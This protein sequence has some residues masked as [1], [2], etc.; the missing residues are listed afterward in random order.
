MRKLELI[1]KEVPI[2]EKARFFGDKDS[3]NLVV[4]WGSPKGAILE[5][6]NMLTGEGHSIGFI[7]VRMLHP[8]PKEYIGNALRNARK[9]ICVENSYSGQL[10]AIIREETGISMNFQ[11]LKYTGRPMTSTEV[12]GALKAILQDKAPERQVLTYGS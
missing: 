12:Y 5:A 3:K 10:A 7:Q 1:D 6:A 9:K 11:V 8:L 2:E 4:S